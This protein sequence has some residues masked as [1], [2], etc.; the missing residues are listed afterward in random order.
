MRR[1][2]FDKRQ[3][4]S[5]KVGHEGWAINRAIMFNKSRKQ[6]KHNNKNSYVRLSPYYKKYILQKIIGGF[7]HTF[8]LHDEFVSGI[9]TAMSTDELASPNLVFKPKVVKLKITVVLLS[10]L[11]LY[12]RNYEYCDVSSCFIELVCMQMLIFTDII[13]KKK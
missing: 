5:S 6:K 13:H 3:Q 10:S 2:V 4:A 11:I 8:V 1:G 9:I 12:L 7:S